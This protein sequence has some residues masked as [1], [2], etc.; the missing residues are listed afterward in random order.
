MAEGGDNYLKD[1]RGLLPTQLTQTGLHSIV[2]GTA[3]LSSVVGS[4]AG[5][6]IAL[7]G[8]GLIAFHGLRRVHFTA[9]LLQ[10]GMTGHLHACL[11]CWV[12]LVSGA[13]L[14]ATDACAAVVMAPLRA[15]SSL[16]F[17]S[18]VVSWVQNVV[19]QFGPYPL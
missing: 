11:L 3:G 10:A 12:P 2:V 9:N 4:R 7:N 5:R 19:R 6:F 16:P 18:V 14:V 1:S 8:L 13:I 15:L 17:A